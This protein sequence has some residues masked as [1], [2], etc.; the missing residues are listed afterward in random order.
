M[1]T[2]AC[3]S[4][5]WFPFSHQNKPKKSPTPCDS[6]SDPHQGGARKYLW[7]VPAQDSLTCLFKKGVR[8]DAGAR[9]KD[10]ASP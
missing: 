4:L 6:L 2:Y 3:I 9:P 5:G 10:R 7:G 1:T 8:G